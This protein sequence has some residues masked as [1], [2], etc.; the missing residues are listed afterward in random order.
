MV[1]LVD[2]QTQTDE[3]RQGSTAL[4]VTLVLQALG[5]VAVALGALGVAYFMA[6]SL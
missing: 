5:T 3:N 2:R 1:H 6:E 4:P